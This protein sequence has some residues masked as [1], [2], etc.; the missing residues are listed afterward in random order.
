MKGKREKWVFS[1]VGEPW[2]VGG[3]KERG[4]EGEYGRCVLCPHMKIEE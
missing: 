3:H 1:G 4:N 2:E